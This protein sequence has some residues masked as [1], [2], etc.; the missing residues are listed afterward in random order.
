MASS[1][2]PPPSPRHSLIPILHVSRQV[3]L[4]NPTSHALSIGDRSG[5]DVAP[6]STPLVCPYCDRPFSPKSSSGDGSAG[7]LSQDSRAH[8]YFQLLEVSN[9]SSR[10]ATPF[11]DSPPSATSINS[12]TMAEGYFSAFFR[13]EHRLGMG[14]NGSVFLCQHVLD[15]TFLGRFAVK[16]IAVGQSKDYLVNALREVRL[17]ETLHHPNI[18]TYHH[19]WLETCRF[20]S[21]GPAVPTLFVLMQWAEGGSLDDFIRARLGVSPPSPG[22]N[23]NDEEPQSRSARIRAFKASQARPELRRAQRNEQRRA[24]RGRAVHF[25]SAAEVKSIFNDVVSG[26]GFLHGKAILHLDLKPGNVLLT[27]DDG[28]LIPRAML[29][30][31][32]TYQ[33]MLRPSRARTGVTGTLEYTAPE[34]LS[35]TTQPSSKVDMWALGMILHILLFF[36]LPYD[37]VENSDISKLEQEVLNYKGFK[38]SIEVIATCKRR[39]FPRAALILLE[40]LLTVDPRTRPTCEQ[41]IAVL[42]EGKLDPLHFNNGSEDDRA[43]LVPVVRPHRDASPQPPPTRDSTDSS[44]ELSLDAKVPMLSL[45]PPPVEARRTSV[46]HPLRIFAIIHPV[47]VVKSALLIVKVMSLS[48]MCK[49]SPPRPLMMF[50]VIALATLD[51][52]SERLG[53]SA[54]LGVAHIGMMR[55]GR[56]WCC[57]Y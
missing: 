34:S 13:E 7:E 56:T 3:V 28:R 27:W 40:E 24:E 47:R 19:A 21:F 37:H 45:P 35:I 31:F 41:I 2:S 12:D 36:R 25:L 23:E 53:V 46:W 4:Y 14:A 52:W 29:S 8:N 26:L 5:T 15:G 55:L 48:Q 43:Q 54:I 50:G 16:K 22:N 10:P 20:S 42:Q 17:L 11:R 44:D 1:S 18:V 51:M 33:D 9:E 30:D 6:K 32:G 39:G 38:P 49:S 57:M